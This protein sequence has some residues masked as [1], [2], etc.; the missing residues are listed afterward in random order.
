MMSETS[1]SILVVDD[2]PAHAEALRRL[3]QTA[4]P[5]A[6]VSVCGSL[7]EYREALAAG[8]PHIALVDLNLPDGRAVDILTAPAEDGPFPIV[9]MTSSGNEQVAVEAMKA[10]ALDY[11][12][13]SP[14]SFA[15]MPH[16]IARVMR[17][18]DLRRG[19]RHAQE[20]LRESEEKY[21]SLLQYS[22]DPIFCFNPNGTYRFV[23]ESF[24]RPF[25]KTPEDIIGKTPHAIL[26]PHEAERRLAQV[27]RVFATGE[28]TESEFKVV[29]AAGDVRY[30]LIMADPIRNTQGHVL[31]VTCLSKDITERV[32][33]EHQMEVVATLSAALRAASSRQEMLP[34]LL[35]QTRELLEADGAMLGTVDPTSGE[36]LL[37]HG[38]GVLEG[39]TGRRLPPKTGMCSRVVATA[40]FYLSNNL[41]TEADQIL[42][43]LLG[44]C[45]AF[46]A[47]PLV[48]QDE[49]LGVL[50]VARQRPI[51]DRDTRQMA[52]IAD[53]AA[54]ALRRATLHEQTEMRLQH[55]IALR[56]VDQS[57]TGSLDLRLVLRVIVQQAIAHLRADAASVLLLQPHSLTLDFAAGQ[58][59]RSREFERTKL[60]IGEGRAGRAA[61]E[62]R[63]L[64]S[65]DLRNQDPAVPRPRQPFP[66]EGFLAQH[67]APLVAKGQLLGVL[68]VFHRQP[69]LP[70]ADWMDFFEALAA[71]TAIAIDGATAF[72]HL[73]RS[74]LALKL[75]YDATI[76][77]WARALDLRDKE[78]EGHSR[79][80]T[81]LTV[82]LA[83]VLGMQEEDLVHVRR[84]ALLHD[85]GKM[86]IP[87]AI[88]LKPGPLTDE[89]WV[90]MRR[91]PQMAFDLLSPIEHLR[92]ALDVPLCHHE[93]WDGSGYPRGLH[94]E[95]IPL[96]ARIFGAVDVWDALTNDRPYRKAWPREK[97]LEHIRSQAGT[98]FDPRVVEAFLDAVSPD[99][100]TTG[101][102]LAC[103]PARP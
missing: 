101:E 69:F 74:N 4:W 84:G 77:G 91:H 8:L 68:E 79:R 102:R 100:M 63:P 9:V 49:V 103:L 10:G 34:L 85:I 23:N 73:Q 83:R 43:D 5:E 54:S 33:R 82:R 72:D 97:A 27:R 1:R 76:E 67:V 81:D 56:T 96:A 78:T 20:A 24:A 60:Q 70:D 36:T 28:S 38:S 26:P 35:D 47:V 22:S 14:T 59:F 86:G 61:L 52:A 95:G 53:I 30:C 62:R 3:L 66:T 98:H 90:I 80:V 16:T 94:G 88:L 75:A 71:Q 11:V 44:G 64:G 13:K 65:S 31:Y 89:E 58:G 41:A 87:D 39:A 18:W 40:Q 51:S 32:E 17:E 12:V 25:G 6:S 55:L 19:H 92:P 46:L 57:I 99:A 37:E 7:G 29:T 50:C 42:P 15:E 45:S 2:E 48:S 21:R 93:K